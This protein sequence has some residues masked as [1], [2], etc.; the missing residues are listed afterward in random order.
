MFKASGQL[1]SI[2][3]LKGKFNRRMEYH[4]LGV[5]IDNEIQS[6]NGKILPV[7]YDYLLHYKKILNC[8]MKKTRRGYFFS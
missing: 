1:V 2:R 6:F 3:P 8:F 4:K 5:K 7:E